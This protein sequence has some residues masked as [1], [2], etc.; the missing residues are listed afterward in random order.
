MRALES[1]AATNHHTLRR[2][3]IFWLQL[4]GQSASANIAKR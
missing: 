4:Q 3:R 1:K 2:L